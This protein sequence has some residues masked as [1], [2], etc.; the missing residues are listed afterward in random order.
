MLCDLCAIEEGIRRGAGR[1]RENHS[2]DWAG[3]L[4][5]G[6]WRSTAAKK[7]FGPN[8]QRRCRA[9]NARGFGRH[10]VRA[11]RRLG[12]ALGEQGHGNQLSRICMG[13]A[14]KV[15][16]IALATSKR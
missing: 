16:E 6:I 1:I 4:A 12:Q 3:L 15:L 7:D 11:S 14:A 13:S 10:Y 8:L 9:E 5:A 2:Y